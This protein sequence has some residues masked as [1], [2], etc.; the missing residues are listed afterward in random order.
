M[1]PNITQM[2]TCVMGH[3]TA[4]CIYTRTTISQTT[5]MK[6]KMLC[7]KKKKVRV[8]D[9]LHVTVIPQ[10]FKPADRAKSCGLRML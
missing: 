10:H 9:Y 2:V 8:E 3:L 4:S 7:L 5:W 6:V 1:C